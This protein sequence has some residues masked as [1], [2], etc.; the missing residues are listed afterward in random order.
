MK[1]THGQTEFRDYW[2]ETLGSHNKKDLNMSATT[3]D[4]YFLFKRVAN[5]LIGLLASYIDDILRAATPSVFQSFK[6][7]P[8]LASKLSLRRL[9]LSISQVYISIIF[10]TPVMPPTNATYSVYKFSM[11]QPGELSTNGAN[12]LVS[13]H[14]RGNLLHSC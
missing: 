5:H 13:G 2:N 10:E 14:L 9:R 4:H 11:S 3:G 12:I 8:A 1:P 7:Q 6:C